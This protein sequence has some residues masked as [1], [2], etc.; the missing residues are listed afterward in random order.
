[1]NVV[2]GGYRPQTPRGKQKCRIRI[3]TAIPTTTAILT[4]TVTRIAIAILIA[5]ATP[6]ATVIPIA[7]AI[8]TATKGEKIMAWVFVTKQSATYKTKSSNYLNDKQKFTIPGVKFDASL[9]SI[10]SGVNTLLGIVGKEA[11]ID[12]TTELVLTKGVEMSE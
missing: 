4:A 5:I 12:N 2:S 8:P 9:S 6:T 1:M 3:L 7:T 11:A 10:N